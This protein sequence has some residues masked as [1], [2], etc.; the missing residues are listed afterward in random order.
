MNAHTT[1]SKRII[2]PLPIPEGNS[3]NKSLSYESPINLNLEDKIVKNPL[4]HLNS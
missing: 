3:D 1:R 2:D 4:I